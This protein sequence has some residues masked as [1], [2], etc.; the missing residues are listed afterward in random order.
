MITLDSSG[1]SI[2]AF[3]TILAEVQAD[4]RSLFG[5]G[6]ATD[7]LSAAGQL[8]RIIAGREAPL[9]EMAQY[10][11]QNTD[12]RNAE[13]VWQDKQ[14]ALLGTSRLP[15]TYAEVLGTAT[16]TPAT[17]IT[18][19]TRL[20]VGGFVFAVVDGP[21]TVGGGGTVTN[22]RLRA[23]AY[24]ATD[25]SLLGAWT[26]VDTI[27]GFTSFDDDTQ[28]IAGRLEET[29]A[30]YNARA[31]EERYRRGTGPLDAIEA[32]VLD[33]EGVT[34]AKA[35]HNVGTATDADGVPVHDVWVVVEGGLDADVAA[36]IADSIAAGTR[37]FG[38]ESASV[39]RGA[40]TE[41]I[42]WDRVTTVAMYANVT[43]TTS[44]SEEVAP[45]DLA[46]QV[47][48]LL[49]TYTDANW[50]Q[51]T[52]VLPY[53]LEGQLVG[54]TGVDNVAITVSDDD[55]VYVA[56]KIAIGRHQRA[57]LTAARIT[58]VEA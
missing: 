26:I 53:R 55:V 43:V 30:E 51:G 37:T 32:A 16:G 35:Y 5:S 31:D 8:Q 56:S 3:D 9:Q 19:G 39:V 21:Y 54:I 48:T 7:N 22:V 49:T 28:P 50:T 34:Y 6:V 36:A 45:T 11:Y 15:D 33:V 1:L 13:G 29:T 12:P 20:S 58:V 38:T 17:S 40:S 44:T 23:Q 18:N 4:F 10:L 42:R 41:T 14:N 46:T 52:D 57:V 47:Q 24:G 27:P 2:D 25:V